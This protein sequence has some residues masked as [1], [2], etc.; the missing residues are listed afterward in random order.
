MDDI[1]RRHT[2]SS[3][4][5]SLVHIKE[6]QGLTEVNPKMDTLQKTE[7]QESIKVPVF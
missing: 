5:H 4:Y 6:K 1:H 2:C 7:R 3:G